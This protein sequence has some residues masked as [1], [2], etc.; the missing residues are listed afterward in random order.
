MVGGGICSLSLPWP[1]PDVSSFNAATRLG[2]ATTGSGSDELGI[3]AISSSASCPLAE[4]PSFSFSSP[5]KLAASSIETT[6]S[7]VWTRLGGARRREEEEE[8]A[9]AATTLRRV[10]SGRERPVGVVTAATTA[11]EG[12]GEAGFGETGTEEDGEFAPETD[13]EER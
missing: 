5:V 11:G 9:E 2:P 12:E 8:E 4:P 13:A 6:V 3:E 1:S 10:R 7:G